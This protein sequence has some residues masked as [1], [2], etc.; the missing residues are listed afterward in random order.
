MHIVLNIALAVI[1]ILLFCIIISIHEFG[2][3]IMAKLFKVKVN[4]FSI[5]MG[6]L[7]FKKQKGETQYS[8]RAL[9]IGGYCSMEGEDEDSNDPA[10]FGNKPAYQ[11]G[12]IIVMGA[13]FNIILGF[14][15]MLIIFSQ[16]SAFTS[17]TIAQFEDNATTQATGLQVNDKIVSVD[18]YKINTFSDLS[19]GLGAS[20]TVRKATKEGTNASVNITVLRN[21][22]YINLPDVNF[23]VIQENGKNTL[24]LDFK[25]YAIQKNFPNL[26]KQA[27][28]GVTSTVRMVWGSLLGLLTGKFSFT[29][30]SGPVGIV[31]AVAQSASQ[32]LAISFVAAINNILY[33]VALITVN[34][35]VFNLL[36]LPALDG[37]R[38]LFVIVEIIT[39]HK[40][41][42]KYERLVHL[43]GLVLLLALMA[44]VTFSDLFK[45][46]TGSI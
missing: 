7:I 21:G 28:Y 9:P 2:H 12:L 45:L 22:E 29:D 23:P 17:T 30:M 19:F 25:V 5:G 20:K 24:E 8:I 6:P 3:F 43:A 36:P 34:L 46:F 35:G 18:G 15:V 33:L 40:V 27:A 37:G 39:R 32:G 41:P 10:S 16:Q 13:V 14:I 26:V 31:S 42:E 38:L 4:E 1:A 11:R 44:A